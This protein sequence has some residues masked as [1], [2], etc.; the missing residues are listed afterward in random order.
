ML[1]GVFICWKY[2]LI[3]LRYKL[4]YECLVILEGLFGETPPQELKN[5]IF[6]KI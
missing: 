1:W 3:L 4:S 6:F 2:I 5:C